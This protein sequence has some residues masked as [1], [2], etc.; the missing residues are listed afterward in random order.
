M[1]KI[2][3]T[4]FDCDSQEEITS[5]NLCD[6][7]TGTLL[8]PPVDKQGNTLPF[9]FKILDANSLIAQFEL[10]AR[11]KFWK[12]E[13]NYNLYQRLM[14]KLIKKR[15]KENGDVK[16]LA[17]EYDETDDFYTLLFSAQINCKKID[18]AIKKCNKLINELCRPLN[19][20]MRN[21]ENLIKNDLN[22]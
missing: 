1:K 20:A 18:Q 4:L 17:A 6:Y 10:S 3:N 19:K 12:G 15:S 8:E 9:S 7:T 21:V 13:L 2:K 14:I 5:N 16:Y 11:N 22:I